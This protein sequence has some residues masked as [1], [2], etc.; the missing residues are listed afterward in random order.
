MEK[1]VAPSLKPKLIRVVTFPISFRYLLR[2][3]L[4]FM[5]QHFELIAVSTPG[6]ELADT[7]A[8]EGVAT[9]GIGLTRKITPFQ[10]LVSLFKMIRFFWRE[11]P[12]IVHS[13][14][15]KAGLIAMMAAK[16]A[17]VPTRIHTVAGMP[18]MVTKG[19]KRQL[20]LCTERLAYACA[21]VVVPNSQGL[22]DYLMAESLTPSAKIHFFE[23]G[24]S[25]GINLAHYQ[26]TPEVQALADTL[27]HQLALQDRF[28]FLFAGR[29]VKDK[30]VEELVTAFVKRYEENP[31]VALM[32]AGDF[33]HGLNQISEATHHLLH[34]HPG[35]HLLGFTPDIRISLAACDVLL[36]PSY[37]E[38]LP[39]VL[40]QACAME[41]PCITTDI[42]GCN[43]VIH[44][45]VNGLIVPPRDW[46]ALAH[47]MK[48]LSEDTGLLNRVTAQARS[49]VQRYNQVAIWGQLL[50]FYM[51][52]LPVK[53]PDGVL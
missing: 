8:D 5:A 43:E 9:V 51:K 17:G 10:D 22:K 37:R 27:A 11:A 21:T 26:R 23:P 48:R 18:L 2:G 39:Q 36:L 41:V 3:Q 4:R 32:M 29:M 20:L 50:G 7:G 35:I 28:V 40:L 53:N 13:H 19:F 47:A 31:T 16:V 49:S 45:E 52:Q 46:E 6:P 44:P 14:T 38:G 33:D 12:D 34:T 30:G 1:H 24:S 15:P 42:M 25:N